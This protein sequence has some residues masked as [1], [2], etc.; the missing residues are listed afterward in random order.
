MQRPAAR[1]APDP[2]VAV[3]ARRHD[4]AAVRAEGRRQDAAAV[5]EH[6]QRVAVSRAPDARRVVVARSEDERSV[7]AER[8]C[9]DAGA[10]WR[11]VASRRAAPRAP[12]TARRA[13]A[14]SDDRRPSGLK[15]ASFRGRCRAV[16]ARRGLPDA[17][18][19]I[20][21]DSVGARGHDERA[22]GVEGGGLGPRPDG[23]AC[24][25][26]VLPEAPDPAVPSARG[27]TQRASRSRS[28]PH[29]GSAP[30]ADRLGATCR[31][32]LGPTRGWCRRRST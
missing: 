30:A 17:T 29:R 18:R 5:M 8:R 31:R 9:P 15:E 23:A 24:A 4:S 28:P 27:I 2:C 6:V 10:P 22:V 7:R 3:A 14:E 32:S 12:E 16:A 26:R 21:S 19:Q 11:S 1:N 20:A 13:R 25:R